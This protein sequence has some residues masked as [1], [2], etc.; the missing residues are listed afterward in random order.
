MTEKLLL[1]V[2]YNFV[3]QQTKRRFRKGDVVFIKEM[4]VVTEDRIKILIEGEHAEFEMRKMLLNR[5]IF[6]QG[7][8]QLGT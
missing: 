3:S 7:A 5:C 2:P 1:R 6:V 4:E 8:K